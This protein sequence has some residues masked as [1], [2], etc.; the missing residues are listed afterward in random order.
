MDELQGELQIA[1]RRMIDV[2]ADAQDD[3][4][5]ES[6]ER[7]QGENDTIGIEFPGLNANVI[8]KVSLA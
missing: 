4:L 5:V 6:F 3:G 2:I 7:I 1:V 8:V